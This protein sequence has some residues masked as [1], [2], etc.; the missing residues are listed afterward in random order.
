MIDTSVQLF[1]W[2]AYILSSGR[3][4]KLKIDCDALT[5][6]DL[7]ACVKLLRA[8]LSEFDYV[9]GIPSGGTALANLMQKYTTKEKG[10]PHIIL[11]V[12]DVFTTGASLCRERDRLQKL[13]PRATIFGAVIFS[14][15]RLTDRLTSLFTLNPR[16]GIV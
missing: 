16:L 9:V 8:I 10:D 6:A 14:R 3:K 1:N 15:M 5:P 2:G 12:D 11:I 4:S 7:L 13:F